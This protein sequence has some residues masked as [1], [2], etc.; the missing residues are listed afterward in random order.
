MANFTKKDISMKLSE[1]LEISLSLSSR[2]VD[3]FTECI[4]TNLNENNDIKISG[5]GTFKIS[6]TPKRVGRNP[7][8]K[9]S[10]IISERKRIK[11]VLS[12]RVRGY[13]N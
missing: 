2:L 6:K 11:L 5:F 10:F 13:I 7:K 8:T 4:K 9:E 3:Y 12:A 1:N